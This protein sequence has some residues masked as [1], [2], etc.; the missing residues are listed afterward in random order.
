MT[1]IIDII[2]DINGNNPEK[3]RKFNKD[4]QSL[5]RKNSL[6]LLSYITTK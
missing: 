4:G 6:Y 5:L 3:V 1:R 2:K